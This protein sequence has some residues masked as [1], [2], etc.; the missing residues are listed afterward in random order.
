MLRGKWDWAAV[1]AQLTGD[2]GTGVDTVGKKEGEADD[3]GVLEAVKWGTETGGAHAGKVGGV[4]GKG[5]GS[6]GG[7]EDIERRCQRGSVERD[8][9]LRRMMGVVWGCG[10]RLVLAFRGDTLGGH[11]SYPVGI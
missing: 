2:I 4:E 8:V 5:G 3:G 1:R 6:G 11:M 9:V 7:K 10:G